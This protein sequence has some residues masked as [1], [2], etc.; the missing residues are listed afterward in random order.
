MN[1][2]RVLGASSLFYFF[3]NPLREKKQIVRKQKYS[4]DET[5]KEFR[6][7]QAFDHS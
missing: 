2:Q 7:S 3:K 4:Y 1:V 6:N 5:M